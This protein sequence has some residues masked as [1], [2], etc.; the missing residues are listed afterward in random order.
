MH[1]RTIEDGF[2]YQVK[3]IINKIKEELADEIEDSEQRVLTDDLLWQNRKLLGELF[4]DRI[5][6]YCGFEDIGVE[7]V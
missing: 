7:E 3:T 5:S 1:I 2:E 6:E 4:Y